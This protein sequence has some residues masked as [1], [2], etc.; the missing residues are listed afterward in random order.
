M[1]AWRT[2]RAE[3]DETRDKLYRLMAEWSQHVRHDRLNDIQVLLGYIRLGKP[4]RL[5][6]YIDAMK[7]ELERESRL[8]KLGVPEL[9]VFLLTCPM[10]WRHLKV[11]LQTGEPGRGDVRLDRLPETGRRV[12]RIVCD[13]VSLI[14]ESAPPS[15]GD[16]LRVEIGLRAEDNELRLR[17]E[18]EGPLP[19]GGIAEGLESIMGRTLTG[20][21]NWTYTFGDNRAALDIRL[22]RDEPAR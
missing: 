4:D 19:S 18:T 13:A 1:D 21:D 17:I 2:D 22:H 10:R 8:A 6:G 7:R 16:V 12:T 14:A 20:G 3:S 11:D 9:V 5:A 15:D